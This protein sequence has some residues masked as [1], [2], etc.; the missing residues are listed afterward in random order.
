MP[1]GY[2]PAERAPSATT[3][4]N[5][6]ATA[7]RKQALSPSIDIVHH[8]EANHR[9]RVAS[10]RET[11][12]ESNGCET[13][14]ARVRTGRRCK[15][16]RSDRVFGAHRWHVRGRGHAVRHPRRQCRSIASRSRACAPCGRRRA[17]RSAD[18]LERR[19]ARSGTPVINPFAPVSCERLRL[20]FDERVRFGASS[21][22]VGSCHASYAGAQTR[23]GSRARLGYTSRTSLNRDLYRSP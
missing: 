11:Q 6:R 22:P 21:L 18:E 14:P 1:H 19:S 8:P 20:A 5:S 4:P 3:I 15:N 10:L 12:V 7:K 13:P 16:E 17:R 2:A 9:K 23:F